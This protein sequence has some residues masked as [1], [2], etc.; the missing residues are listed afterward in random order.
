VAAKLGGTVTSL[1]NTASTGAWPSVAGV[2]SGPMTLGVPG[3]PEAG[4]PVAS[5]VGAWGRFTWP[6]DSRRISTLFDP[7]HQAIDI[8]EW[9][10]GGN[11]VRAIAAGIVSFA[12]WQSCCSYGLYVIVQHADGYSSLYAHFSSLAVSQGQAVVQGQELGRSG[13]TG[14]C[15]GDHL[16]FA[17]YLHGAPLDP[18]LVLPAG[19]QLE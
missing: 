14:S 17:I 5:G 7:A 18:L 6:V 12:G 11:P 15:T 3:P 4:L 10:G 9:P 13:C 19:A 16:H 2:A 8:D 1:A